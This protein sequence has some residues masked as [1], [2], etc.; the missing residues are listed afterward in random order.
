M[1][2]GSPSG[3]PVSV[4]GE[5]YGGLA[6]AGLDPEVCAELAGRILERDGTGG[7]VQAT[8]S[9]LV[10]E[11]REMVTVDVRIG[12]D[13]GGA[14]VVALVGPPGCGKTTTLVK[15]AAKYGLRARRPACL[16]SMDM[17]RIGVAEQLRPFTAILG[18][19]FAA[20]E[21]PGALSQT[22][23]EHHAKGLVLIDTP[24]F[25]AKDLDAAEEVAAVLC[26]HPEAEIHLALSATM[27]TDDIK[28]A[29][30]RYERFRPRKLIF[31]KL[32]ETST[33]GT[34]LNE[35][36]RTG[37]P[38]SFLANGPN[39]PEDLTEATTDLL[40]DLVGIGQSKTAPV[41]EVHATGRAAAA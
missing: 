6:T 36:V 23:E 16:V 40:L 35:A 38:V 26:G 8:A 12:E 4:L 17:C 31:T 9:L 11:L 1:R 22:L 25:G 30:H 39:I 41:E 2:D 33:Q 19:S 24:G 14:R 29:V 34:I 18:V 20:L 3:M 21:V 13:T 5:W 28:S 7:S 37:K 15:L 10:R 32:D 27:K